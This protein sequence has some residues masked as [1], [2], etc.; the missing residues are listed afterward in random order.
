MAAYTFRYWRPNLPPISSLIYIS[1]PLTCHS[2]G[3]GRSI[4]AVAAATN[5]ARH[6]NHDVLS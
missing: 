2:G 4:L 3:F 5:S 6:H 1:I